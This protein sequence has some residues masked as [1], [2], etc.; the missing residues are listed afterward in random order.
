[1]LLVG[2]SV[3][4][5]YGLVQV[6]VTGL[7]NPFG[8]DAVQWKIRVVTGWKMSSV[9]LVSVRVGF[10]PVQF[11]LGQ[12]AVAPETVVAAAKVAGLVVKVRFPFLI[13]LAGIAVSDS[14]GPVRTLF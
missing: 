13:A 7:V 5:C 4:C 3:V 6:R 8:F 12:P 9:I 14:A 2:S 11:G 1:V 10:T